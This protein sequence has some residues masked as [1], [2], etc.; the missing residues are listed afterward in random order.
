MDYHKRL[1]YLVVAL[2]AALFLGWLDYAY[3]AWAVRDWLKLELAVVILALVAA[4]GGK[5]W[6]ERNQ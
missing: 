2:Y 6:T 3:R 5:S 1:R 4:I